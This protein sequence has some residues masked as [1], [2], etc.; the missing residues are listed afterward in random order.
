[1]P[2]LIL[3]AIQ[4]IRNIRALNPVPEKHY[5]AHNPHN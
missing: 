2:E 1:M 5:S 4:F 3:Q